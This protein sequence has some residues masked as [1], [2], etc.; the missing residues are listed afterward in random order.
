MKKILLALMLLPY[1]SFGICSDHIKGSGTLKTETRTLDSFNKLAAAG[2]I[3]IIIEQGNT[4]GVEVTADDN[5]LT[6]IITEVKN[7]TLS[8]HLK[9]KVSVISTKLVVKVKCKQLGNISAGG[10]G[11]IKTN[12][13]FKSEQLLINQG[14]SGDF[15]LNLNVRELKISK[16]G[17]GDFRIEGK[18]ASMDVSSAGSGDLDASKILLGDAEISMAGSGDIILPKGSKPKVSNVGSGEVHYE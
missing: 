17:S 5:L 1:L 12:S 3:D 8:V 15:K 4:E 6:Y 10:S 11:D 18:V 7:N 2:S 14:G 9:E 16:A 13:E